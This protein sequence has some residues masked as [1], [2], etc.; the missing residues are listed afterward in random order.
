MENPPGA[1]QA[2]ATDRL[3]E[4]WLRGR[5]ARVW[6]EQPGLLLFQGQVIE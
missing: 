3:Q 6:C 5:E 2:L 4:T 1:C